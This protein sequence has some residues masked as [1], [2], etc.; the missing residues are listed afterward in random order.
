MGGTN[1]IN[2][3]TATP[4]TSATLT[5][6]YQSGD[7]NNGEIFGMM[8][9]R[10]VYVADYQRQLDTLAN[11]IANGEIQ[12]TIPVG[13]VLPGTTT[14]L[15]NPTTV[16]VNGING[17]HKLGYTLEDPA[18]AGLDFFTFKTGASGIT[19][20]SIQL[21]P[22]IASDTNKI[23]TSM[24]TTTN[25]GV[26]TVVKGNN[27]LALLMSELGNVSFKFD[28]SAAGNGISEAT[29]SNFYSSMV[30][31][32]GVQSEEAQRQYQ[33]SQAMADQVESSR[34]S[35]SGVSLD[36][37]MSDLIKYQHA[38]S[39]AARFMTTFDEMLDKLINGTGT[40]GR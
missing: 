34:Q 4:L 31:A 23:A 26:S 28:Q 27:S 3:G 9:S 17:L 13:S 5:T 37:E 33:N 36:E 32:L 6:A 38:Y 18:K 11:T 24:R 14:P 20:S 12:V 8:T 21:N 40:V 39:A 22:A 7:L 10:D 35:V 15:A 2:G 16:T 19:A 29:I 1:L 25:N 30:G